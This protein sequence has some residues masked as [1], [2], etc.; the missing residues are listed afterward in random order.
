LGK[1]WLTFFTGSSELAGL[2]KHFRKYIFVKDEIGNIIYFRFYEP[3]VLRTFLPPC[4]L[5]ELTMFF[6]I[7]GKFLFEGELPYKLHMISIE[8][9]RLKHVS[10]DL[11][12]AG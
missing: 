2:R 7:V 1:R 3:S 4:N 10:I 11:S 5:E 8:N 12:A 6:G 9:S